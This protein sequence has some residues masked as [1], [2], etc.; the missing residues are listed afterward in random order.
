MDNGQHCPNI[1]ETIKQA[2]FSPTFE[3]TEVH[4]YDT[5]MTKTTLICSHHDL[6]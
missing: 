4:S 1:F 5:D 6:P 3:S 2:T